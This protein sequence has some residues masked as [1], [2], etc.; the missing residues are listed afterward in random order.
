MYGVLPIPEEEILKKKHFKTHTNKQYLIDS[1][2][3]L[4]IEKD[5]RKKKR[6]KAKAI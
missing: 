2:R 1:S 6:P 5:K 4:E 3:F